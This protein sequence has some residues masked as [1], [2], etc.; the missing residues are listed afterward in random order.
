MLKRM[1]DTAEHGVI[2][3]G[4]EQVRRLQYHKRPQGCGLRDALP[5]PSEE[6][7][8]GLEQAALEAVCVARKALALAAIATL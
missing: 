2:V 3:V 1:R 4:G 7:A 6:E 8:A 5:L